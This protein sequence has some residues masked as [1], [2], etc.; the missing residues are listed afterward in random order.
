MSKL[1]SVASLYE[2]SLKII[3]QLLII[4]DRRKEHEK[5]IEELLSHPNAPQLHTSMSRSRKISSD[6]NKKIGTFANK[7]ARSANVRFEA[8]PT[9]HILEVRS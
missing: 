2:I 3:A 6:S 5:H 9:V 7:W 4:F 1:H 8:T